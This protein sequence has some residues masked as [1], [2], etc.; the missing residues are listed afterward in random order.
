MQASQS[1]DTKCT[2]TDEC[3]LVTKK[4]WNC[5]RPPLSHLLHHLH[6]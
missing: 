3:G 4:Q 6:F 5:W 1:S 2:I